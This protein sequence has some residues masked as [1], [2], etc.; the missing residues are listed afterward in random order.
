MKEEK[1]D[2]K[3]G[4]KVIDFEEFGSQKRRNYILILFRFALLTKSGHT[5]RCQRQEDGSLNKR[6]CSAVGFRC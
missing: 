6:P 5:E 1:V 4:N 3:K 2:S